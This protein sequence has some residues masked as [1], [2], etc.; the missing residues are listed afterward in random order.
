MKTYQVYIC[1]TEFVEECD[2]RI[3]LKE[4]PATRKI[5]MQGESAIA[6]L[7]IID[8]GCKMYIIEMTTVD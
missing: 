3:P 8:P 1:P 7:D 6:V 4:H 5:T 2:Y